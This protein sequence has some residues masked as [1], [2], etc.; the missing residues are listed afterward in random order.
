MEERRLEGGRRLKAGKLS[1]AEIARELGVSR[2]TVST[3]AKRLQAGGLRQLHRRRG[4]GRSPKL[5]RPQECDLK[6]RL[7]R[8]ALAMGFPT[9]RWTM[10]RVQLLIQREFGVT[11]HPNYINRLLGRLDWSLQVPLPRA[12]ER[13]E[14][15]VRAWLEQDWPRIKKGAAQRRRDRVFR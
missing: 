8:G 1:Q 15:W 2:T 5:T 4:G 7:R 9:D 12:L 11:Y 13:D 6:R 3:W 14:D 10:Q